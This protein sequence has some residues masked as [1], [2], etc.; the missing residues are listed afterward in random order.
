[1]QCAHALRFSAGFANSRSKTFTVLVHRT[2]VSFACVHARRTGYPVQHIVHK[3]T[4]I[5]MRDRDD[6][7][8]SLT[9]TSKNL[10]RSKSA[11]TI[12][13]AVALPSAASSSAKR[14]R[15][16]CQP[17]QKDSKRNAFTILSQKNDL[18]ENAGK[19][20]GSVQSSEVVWYHDHWHPVDRDKCK[21]K[22][23]KAPQQQQAKN[24]TTCGEF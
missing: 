7:C 10:K 1:M 23:L 3:S 19:G 4:L 20:R 13:C 14:S 2:T 6:D 17:F 15:S 9:D 5:A 11:S 12:R 18:K 22:F 16:S 24:W 21:G 8:I